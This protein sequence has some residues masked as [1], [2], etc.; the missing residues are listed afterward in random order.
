MPLTGAP[1]KCGPISV[2]N[3]SNLRSWRLSKRDLD[4]TSKYRRGECV[5]SRERET[6]TSVLTAELQEI[7]IGRPNL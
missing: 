4:G 3:V 6:R 7:D 5:R 1:E 2:A